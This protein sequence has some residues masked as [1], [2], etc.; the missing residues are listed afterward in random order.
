MSVSGHD[1]AAKE[2]EAEIRR[3]SNKQVTPSVH[4][5]D[6]TLDELDEDR[7]SDVEAD[8]GS[9]TSEDDDAASSPPL[10][11]VSSRSPCLTS[12]EAVSLREAAVAQKIVQVS[13][14]VATL[15]MLALQDV[16]AAQPARGIEGVA[17]SNG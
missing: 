13:G 17:K 7:N 12:S 3:D 8:S 10:C 4:W 14:T 16:S 1:D 11:R 15:A 5:A 2:V 6:T 9:D